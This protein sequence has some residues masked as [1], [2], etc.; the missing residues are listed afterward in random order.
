MNPTTKLDW[1]EHSPLPEMT[2][3]QAAIYWK[4][5]RHTNNPN[6]RPYHPAYPFI[7]DVTHQLEFNVLGDMRFYC[8]QCNT[9]WLVTGIFRLSQGPSDFIFIRGIEREFALHV[10]PQEPLEIL[11]PSGVP[12]AYENPPVG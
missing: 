4:I 3:E 10:H 6:L 12:L 11:D 9:E 8:L 1:S 7:Y 5:A 2:P